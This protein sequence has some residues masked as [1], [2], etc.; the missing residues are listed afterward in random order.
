MTERKSPK[1]LRSNGG[2][3]V[4][5][6]GVFNDVEVLTKVE[7]SRVLKCGMSTLP[8]LGLPIIRMGRSVKYLKRDLE[9]YLLENRQGGTNE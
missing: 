4:I 7:A 8:K 2:E 5:E 9:T 3:R 6:S 1:A